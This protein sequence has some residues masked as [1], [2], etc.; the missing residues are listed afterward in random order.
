MPSPSGLADPHARQVAVPGTSSRGVVIAEPPISQGRDVR[1]HEPLTVERRPPRATAHPASTPGALWRRRCRSGARAASPSAP[2]RI[3]STR[4]ATGGRGSVSRWKTAATAPPCAVPGKPWRSAGNVTTPR[5]ASAAACRSASSIVTAIAGRSGI[6][7]VAR[8]S[9]VRADDLALD[10]AHD[11]A[12]DP[13]AVHD[14]V[15][16]HVDSGYSKRDVPPATT[17]GGCAALLLL[18]AGLLGSGCARGHAR[19]RARRR[20]RRPGSPDRDRAVHRPRRVSVRPRG[21]RHGSPLLGAAADAEEI[22][23]APRTCRLPRAS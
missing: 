6:G 19:H 5:A 10:L 3:S 7:A 2:Q 15:L 11:R 4:S 17:F 9:A 20:R 12:A 21:A 23:R 16:G 18:L 1:R 8:V 14:R 13:A 22:G